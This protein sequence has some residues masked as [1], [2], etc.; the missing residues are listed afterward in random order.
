MNGKRRENLGELTG[1]GKQPVLCCSA[2]DDDDARLSCDDVIMTS[3]SSSSLR[4]QSLP[5]LLDATV[6]ATAAVV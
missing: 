5:V 1:V 4:L 6:A 2:L 3:W